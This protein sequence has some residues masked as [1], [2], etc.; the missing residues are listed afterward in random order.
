MTIHLGYSGLALLGIVTPLL[1]ASSSGGSEIKLNTPQAIHRKVDKD[2]SRVGA[3]LF[4]RAIPGVGVGNILFAA[5]PLPFN[6]EASYRNVGEAFTFE[7]IKGSFNGRAYY[8]GELGSLIDAVLAKNPTYKFKEKTVVMWWYPTWATKGVREA[9]Q[10]DPLGGAAN[11]YDQNLFAILPRGRDAA[12]RDQDLT[13]IPTYPPGTHLVQVFVYL[14]F[15]S[16]TKKVTEA[17]DGKLITQV[18]PTFQDFLV[19]YGQAK[20]EFK[21]P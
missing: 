5:G 16:G 19:A 9:Q 12:F 4:K 1:T 15:N 13:T 8:P 14:K 21:V 18:V 20:I 17:K 10:F 2:G 3:E 6:Q 7:Q 11:K